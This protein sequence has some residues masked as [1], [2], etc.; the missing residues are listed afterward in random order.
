[1]VGTH[2]NLEI[3]KFAVD[4]LK[5]LANKFLE[6]EELSSYTYQKDFLKPFEA[7]L[8]HNLHTR[9]DVKDLIIACAVSMA[10]R[11][12]KNIKSGWTVLF[13]IYRL[14]ANDTDDHNITTTL[15]CF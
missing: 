14:A 8:L 10:A 1:M 6:K 13:N 12:A 15:K 11:K 7:I 2:S 3:S 5:Q 9:S 4:N